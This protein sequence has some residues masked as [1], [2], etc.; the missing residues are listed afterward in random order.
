ME[1]LDSTTYLAVIGDLVH[2]RE[3]ADRAGLQKRFAGVLRS[4]NR[5]CGRVVASQFRILT[6]DECE[7]LL[8]ADAPVYEILREIEFAVGVGR[9]RFGIGR[10]TLAI[11]PRQ[12]RN[13][14]M[15]DG[16]AFHRARAAL[17]QAR[18]AQTDDC[19]VL[20]Q[21]AG[22]PGDASINTILSLLGV[23]FGQITPRRREVYETY[24]REGTIDRA[25][26][27]LGIHRSTVGKALARQSYH[28]LIAAEAAI[29]HLLAP[30][31]SDAPPETPRRVS[32]SNESTER[33]AC[34]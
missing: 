16:P 22:F 7:G 2:S 32:D 12:F 30:D 28:H 19:P 8:A 17:L 29:G 4:L 26:R 18:E 14:G 6:G 33:A 3:S 23:A 5:R 24:R 27:R 31:P 15:L 10:G 21:V 13:V 9:I 25:A 34:C 20:A 1:A 11:S